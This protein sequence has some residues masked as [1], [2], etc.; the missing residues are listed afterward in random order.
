[1]SWIVSSG[2]IDWVICRKGE[3]AALL[4]RFA[5]APSL[6][7]PGCCS[8]P[9]VVGLF[10]V[11]LLWRSAGFKARFGSGGSCGRAAAAL[12]D[13]RWSAMGIDEDGAAKS[14]GWY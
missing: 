9:A 10:G 7:G 6:L 14:G 2:G 13:L 3:I 4:L 8:A 5:G 1:M 12:A 11:A